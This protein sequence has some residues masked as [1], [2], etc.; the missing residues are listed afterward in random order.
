MCRYTF[1]RCFKW[2]N[3]NAPPIMQIIETLHTLTLKESL[4]ACVWMLV[5]KTPWQRTYKKLLDTSIQMTWPGVKASLR[6]ALIL[7]RFDSILYWYLF[8]FLFQNLKKTQEVF[9]C[10]VFEIHRLTSS[11]WANHN[12]QSMF[13]L[14]QAHWEMVEVWQTTWV[15]VL[16]WTVFEYGNCRI[17]VDVRS[18]AH[19]SMVL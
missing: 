15:P 2:C 17:S 12:R 16:D 10:T 13:C 6:G 3:V 5:L 4:V 7:T 19:V 14:L 9:P 11:L 8:N 18:S 1:T